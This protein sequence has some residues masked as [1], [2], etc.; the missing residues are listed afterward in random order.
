MEFIRGLI[1]LRQRQQCVAT[2]G[3]FDGVHLGHR[4][5]IEQLKALSSQSGLPASIIIF[6][7]Q[8][9]EFFSKKHAPARLMWLRDKLQVFTQY[10]IDQ[11]ICLR[12][13]SD[14]AKQDARFF[15]D[16]ILYRCIGVRYL[17]VGDDFRFGKDRRGNFD[18]L[19]QIGP[20]ERF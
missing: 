19:T 8:P 5:V 17:V 13:N 4:A 10:E 7:P 16:N 3:N 20:G 11:V 2:I 6:E 1:N 15:A 12:F 18:L 9:V 14:I